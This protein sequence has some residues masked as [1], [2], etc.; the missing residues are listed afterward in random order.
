MRREVVYLL[1]LFTGMSLFSCR[2]HKEHTRTDVS[3]VAKKINHLQTVT[4]SASNHDSLMRA[5]KDLLHMPEVNAHNLYA[6][7]VNFQLAKGYGMSKQNDSAAFYLEKAFVRI[8]AEPGNLDEKARIYQGIGNVSL[9]DGHLHRANYYYNKAAAIVLADS[10][11]DLDAS[12]KASI[13]L[14]A[15]QSNQQFQRLDLAL[16][17]NRTALSI[18]ELLPEKHINRQ[19]PLTQL[20]QTLYYSK[21]DVDSIGY[22]VQ[23]LEDLQRKF[24]EVYDVFFVYE[25]K[26]LYYDLKNEVDSVLKYQLLKIDLQ[27]QVVE[28]NPLVGTAVNNLFISYV[29]IAGLYADRKNLTEAQAFFTKAD[30]LAQRHPTVMVYDNAI[31]YHRN[32]ENFYTLSGRLAQALTESREVARIQE[33]LYAM[34]NTQ[35][36]AEMSSLYEIQA[37]ERSIN[38]LNE[39]LQIKELELQRNRLWMTMGIL[40]VLILLLILSFIYYGIRQRRIRQ[41]KDKVILKQQLLRTQME[42]HFIFNTLTALQ[43]YIRRGESNEAIQYLSRFS[44]LLRNSLELSREEWSSLDQEIETLKHYL[45]LQQMRFDHAFSY[46]IQLP[47]G[48]D[49]SEIRIPPMLIQPFVENAI[50]HGVDMKNGEGFISID[51]SEVGDLLRVDIMDSGRVKTER[52]SPSNHRSLSGDISRERLTLLGKNARVESDKN[53]NG[54]TTVTLFIPIA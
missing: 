11:V 19:R 5:W 2:E 33:E 38:S 28:R 14:A 25:S 6:A 10:T 42:P 24:P 30:Q 35:A 27:E 44:K 20:V 21:S 29:N 15:A 16:E 18:S 3:S 50:L 34:Q 17:M 36:I 22:F 9:A 12:A 49:T 43:S 41:E 23:K 51:F 1:I 46:R 45:V 26:T 53:D 8:E 7:K 31:V 37:Q 32:L 4:L 47:D 39:S 40:V 48:M 13:L 52:K 54:G